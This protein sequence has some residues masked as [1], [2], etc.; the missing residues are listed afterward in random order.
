MLSLRLLPT[1]G[2]RAR[3]LNIHISGE[4][5]SP[6]PPPSFQL[7]RVPS[8]IEFTEI[9]NYF[10]ALKLPWLKYSSNFGIEAPAARPQ[11]ELIQTTR[12]LFPVVYADS[13]F[14]RLG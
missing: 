14:I 7:W 5:S 1:N 2:A 11:L 3:A 9:E 10:I 13:R 12:Y 8:E 4:D 6:P